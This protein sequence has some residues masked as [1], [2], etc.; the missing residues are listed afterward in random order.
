MPAYRTL[1]YPTADRDPYECRS[2]GETRGPLHVAQ[3]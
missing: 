1:S 2:H 3:A